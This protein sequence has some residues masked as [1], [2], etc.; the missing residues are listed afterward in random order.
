MRSIFGVLVM[1]ALVGEVRATPG[2]TIDTAPASR[3]QLPEGVT[4]RGSKLERALTFHDKAGT[5]YVVF[6]STAKGNQSAYLYV[7]DWLIAGKAKPVSKLP[8]RDMVDPCEMGG[9]DVRF[10][11]A[12]TAV[13]D[14]DHD[15]LAELTFSYELACRSDVSPATY[16]LL[17][18]EDGA[19]L[20]LRGTTRVDDDGKGAVLGGEFTPDPAPAKWPTAFLEHAKQRWNATADD[21]QIPPHR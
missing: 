3:A 5:H 10:H 21:A 14:L 4:V 11:D 12:A 19:K 16:K 20:I 6:S 2:T 15:G 1:S 7:D 13:T 18:I 9:I 17:V 8:V